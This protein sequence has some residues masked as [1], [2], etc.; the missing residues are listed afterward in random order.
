MSWIVVIF[1][2]GAVPFP[3]SPC[4]DLISKTI[5]SCNSNDKNFLKIPE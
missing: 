1:F 4:G 3:A 2:G 5:K